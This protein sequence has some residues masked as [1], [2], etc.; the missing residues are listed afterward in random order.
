MKMPQL[1]KTNQQPHR[2]CHKTKDGSD[3]KATPQT[4]KQYCFFHDP[5]TQE[6]RA[7]ARRTGAA[8]RNQQP[9]PL[10]LSI[11]PPQSPSEVIELLGEIMVWVGQGKLDTRTANCLGHMSNIALSAMKFNFRIEC[12]ERKTARAGAHAAV[13]GKQPRYTNTRLQIT[14]I[15]TGESRVI[16]PNPDGKTSTTTIIH[17]GRP[18]RS[19]QDDT[20]SA[21][22]SSANPG[23]E[24]AGSKPVQPPETNGYPGSEPVSPPSRQGGQ[25]QNSIS[26]EPV[27]GKRPE[28]GETVPASPA[29]PLL[30]TKQT[31]VRN[32]VKHGVKVKN[33]T[34]NKV[35]SETGN[36]SK[37]EVRQEQS[38]SG[39]PG[40]SPRHLNYLN[41]PELSGVPLHK[42]QRLPHCYVNSMSPRRA[43]LMMQEARNRRRR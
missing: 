30:S 8:I 13:S 34:E 11:K 37:N 43:E 19:P 28:P 38:F 29:P 4:G 21:V 6:K 2:C 7:E 36:E 12:E 40:L 23:L 25:A 33:E 22:N 20:P 24:F 35:R 18:V 1:F 31:E 26:P 3:C 16:V 27:A 14:S 39:V 32:E 15:A 17:P 42:K 9:A 5:A 10:N 41:Y